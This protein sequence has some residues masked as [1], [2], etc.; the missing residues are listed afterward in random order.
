MNLTNKQIAAILL[1]A[2]ELEK[3]QS[4]DSLNKMIAF[5]LLFVDVTFD[6]ALQVAEL[7]MSSKNISLEEFR[8]IEI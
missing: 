7:V 1:Y 3:N 4:N 8:N 2:D 5:I 6:K